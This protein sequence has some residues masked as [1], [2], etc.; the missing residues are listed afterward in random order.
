[1]K[2]KNTGSAASRRV[3]QWQGASGLCRHLTLL[4]DGRDRTV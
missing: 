3:L 2:E 4:D 1:M